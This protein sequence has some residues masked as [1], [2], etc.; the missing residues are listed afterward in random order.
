MDSLAWWIRVPR[1]ADVVVERHDYR[2]ERAH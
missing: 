1:F 2:M